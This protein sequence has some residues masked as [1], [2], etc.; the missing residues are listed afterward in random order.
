MIIYLI[1]SYTRLGRPIGEV[2]H[3]LLGRG[4]GG[5]CE[6]RGVGYF[7]RVVYSGWFLYIACL[8]FE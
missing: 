2:I 5:R 1:W 3:V 8:S 6:G 4:R 7:Q